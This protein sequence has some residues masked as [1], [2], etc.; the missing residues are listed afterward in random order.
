MVE[1][2]FEMKPYIVDFKLRPRVT[3]I[4]GDTS[5]GKSL[6]Y[7][8]LLVQ[9]QLPE[10]KEKYSNIVLL[11]H[12]SDIRDIV[13][14]EGKL[15]VID[16]AD[17]LLEDAPDMVGHIAADYPNEYLIICRRAYDFDAS[18]NHYATI[19]E[20]RGVFTLNYQFDV[21]GWR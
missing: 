5:S 3:I 18:P 4:R 21:E 14:K 1:I 17:L 8:W 20:V 9:K 7:Q 11:N 2:K 15:F 10:N 6:F 16:N 19:K 13:G 12:T